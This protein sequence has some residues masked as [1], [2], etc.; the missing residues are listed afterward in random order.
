MC[1]QIMEKDEAIKSLQDNLADT[2]AQYTKCYNDVSRSVEVVTDSLL[3][4]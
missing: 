4:Y 1:L 2:K 3:V